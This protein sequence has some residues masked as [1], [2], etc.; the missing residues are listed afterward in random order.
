MVF[1]TRHKKAIIP[2]QQVDNS[3]KDAIIEESPV[4]VSTLIVP[5]QTNVITPASVETI[6]QTVS[7]ISASESTLSSPIN[8]VKPVPVVVEPVPVVVEPVPV[9]VEP[10]PV[11]TPL[12]ESSGLSSENVTDI[13]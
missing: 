4:I 1:I 11:D 5:Q 3:T 7:M 10:V 8:L 6:P 2:A 13:K 12:P 9:V